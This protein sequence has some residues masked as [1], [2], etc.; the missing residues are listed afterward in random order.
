MSPAVDFKVSSLN[1][2]PNLD[3]S[4]YFTVKIGRVSPIYLNSVN[5]YATK[6]L[7]KKAG[8]RAVNRILKRF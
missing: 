2:G 8:Q 4:F 3:P 7:A 1:V 6:S 5:R